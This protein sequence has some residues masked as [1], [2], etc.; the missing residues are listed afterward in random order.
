M[1][2]KAVNNEFFWQARASL[3][4][5]TGNLGEQDILFLRRRQAFALNAVH[6]CSD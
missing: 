2:F 4:C 6:L 5:G 3:E 1:R